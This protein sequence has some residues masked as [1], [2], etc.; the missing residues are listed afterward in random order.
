VRGNIF[1]GRAERGPFL[2][3]SQPSPVSTSDEI[4]MVRSCDLRQEPRDFAFLN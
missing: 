1:G 2:E 3:G 4:K